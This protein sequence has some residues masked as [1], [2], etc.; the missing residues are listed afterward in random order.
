MIF[1]IN[2][3][4]IRVAMQKWEDNFFIKKIMIRTTLVKAIQR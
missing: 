3:L 4:N 2:Y 1:N